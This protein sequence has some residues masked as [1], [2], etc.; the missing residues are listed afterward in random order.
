MCPTYVS[1]L[2]QVNRETEVRGSGEYHRY[3]IGYTLAM[4]DTQVMV[5]TRGSGVGAELQCSPYQEREGSGGCIAVQP[6]TYDDPTET[7]QQNLLQ[8][9]TMSPLSAP[10]SSSLPSAPP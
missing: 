7:L 9:D 6:I 1:F 4:G 10:S 3:L 8:N 5:S 2:T